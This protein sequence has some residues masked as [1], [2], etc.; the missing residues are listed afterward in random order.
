MFFI[1]SIYRFLF[2]KKKLL[3]YLPMTNQY[4]LRLNKLLNFCHQSINTFYSS[5]LNECLYQQHITIRHVFWRLPTDAVAFLCDECW[6]FYNN[7]IIIKYL[8]FVI[9]LSPM[10]LTDLLAFDCYFAILSYRLLHIYWKC[11]TF[12]MEGIKLF[13][14]V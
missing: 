3:C 6:H 1:L 14:S 12:I 4:S 7:K 13:S 5:L 11:Y 10:R 2:T 9:N 8:M